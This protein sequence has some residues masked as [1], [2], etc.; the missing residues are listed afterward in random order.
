M[1]LEP[2]DWAES[3]RQHAATLRTVAFGV[4]GPVLVLGNE[5]AWKKVSRAADAD[6]VGWLFFA[7]VGVQV[8][9][10]IV[11]KYADWFGLY[12]ALM[13]ATRTKKFKVAEWW[14]ACDSISIAAD[15]V[16]AA[17]LAY[18]AYLLFG[19]LVA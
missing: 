12:G 9:L 1:G 15:V 6:W 10:A 8:A 2:K 11:D 4:G 13:G 14:L 3:Y 19:I 7:A 16:A 17:C 5:K 18:A